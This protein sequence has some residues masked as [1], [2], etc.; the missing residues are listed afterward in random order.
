MDLPQH[1]L[2]TH[3]DA[4]S[5]DA[6]HGP[7]AYD[8]ML[9]TSLTQE[10]RDLLALFESIRQR[11]ELGRHKEIPAQLCR[12]QASLEAHLLNERLRLFSYLEDALAYQPQVMA[13]VLA[14][15]AEAGRL[16]LAVKQIVEQFSRQRPSSATAR[17]L[18]A[19]LNR[20]GET[21]QRRFEAEDRDLYPLYREP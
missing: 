19:A 8:P 14:F 17:D 3:Y 7:V 5:D 16:A 4:G 15:R 18:L 1:P 11:A 2:P 6:P 13:R 12:L 9:V 20:L 10:H 21:L